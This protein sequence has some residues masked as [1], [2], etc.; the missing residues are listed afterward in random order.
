MRCSSWVKEVSQ[1]SDSLAP[2]ARYGVDVSETRVNDWAAAHSHRRS[3]F[4]DRWIVHPFAEIC[5][6]NGNAAAKEVQLP[7][8]R[9]PEE[10]Y[11]LVND[12]RR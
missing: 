3:Q 6:S 8:L 7:F 10:L 12:P 5:R 1:E 9:G 2:P 11:S 4:G